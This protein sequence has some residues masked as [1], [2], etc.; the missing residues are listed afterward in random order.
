MFL[1]TKKI[2]GKKGDQ[3]LEYQTYACNLNLTYC[4]L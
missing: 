2:V 4:L 1:I 3:L